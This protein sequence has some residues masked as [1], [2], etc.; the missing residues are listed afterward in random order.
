MEF[1]A[2]G[3]SLRSVAAIE[4]SSIGK[5]YEA[6]D[7]L[8][9]AAGVTLLLARTICSGKYLV[10]FAGSA[11]DV[12]AALA[13]GV[14]TGG[15][16]VIDTTFTANIHESVAPALGMAVTPEPGRVG[17]LGVVEGFCSAGILGAANLAAKA[18][19]IT[20]LRIHLA[21]ALG[22]KGL[23]LM[24]GSM[25][26]VETGVAVAAEEMRSKG[27]LAS[28]VVIPNPSPELFSDYL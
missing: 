12:E 5:G 7:T 24:V 1:S 14:K 20:L 27:M 28:A 2:D 26:D 25:S 22:G 21:M 11:G 19:G 17:A 9:K 13:A 15:E 3:G 4:F 18:A 8:L 23:I 16:A 10:V 6:Q